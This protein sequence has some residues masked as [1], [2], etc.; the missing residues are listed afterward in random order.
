M[1]AH[2][3]IWFAVSVEGQATAELLNR[4]EVEQ[5]NTA[6]VYK[7]LAGEDRTIHQMVRD[8]PYWAAS[9]VQVGED[10]IDLLARI[11]AWDIAYYM[12][13]GEFALPVELRERMQKIGV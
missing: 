11:K 4:L 6:K 10:A 3:N 12:Q 7:N 13:R 2:N 1:K 5:M 9:R 8:E